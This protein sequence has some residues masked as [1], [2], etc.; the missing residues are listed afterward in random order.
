MRQKITKIYLNGKEYC[1]D[2]LVTCETVALMT[3]LSKRTI[4]DMAS[5]RELPMY[6][7][8]KRA[9]RYKV[10]EIINWMEARRVS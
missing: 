10:R 2:E 7:L 3:G 8:G 4:E 9:N 6:K 5:R 1:G